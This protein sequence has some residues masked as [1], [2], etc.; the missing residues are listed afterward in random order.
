MRNHPVTELL[1][2]RV[3]H[4]APRV[5]GGRL[6]GSGGRAPQNYRLRKPHVASVAADVA[7]I[8]RLG[9]IVLIAD[10]AAGRVDDPGALLQVLEGVLVDQTLGALVQRCVDGQDIDLRQEVLELLDP[11][12]PD[13]LGGVLGQR[14]V[15]ARSDCL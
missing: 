13:L 10:G 9:H 12:G 2:V 15:A 5:I 3:V 14:G 11:A 7:R 6:R 1:V 8:E 4:R